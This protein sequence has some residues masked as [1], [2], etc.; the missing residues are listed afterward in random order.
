MLSDDGRV[1][2]SDLS[3]REK[4][5][6][7]AQQSVNFSVVLVGAILTVSLLHGMVPFDDGSTFLSDHI[8]IIIKGGAFYLLYVEVFSP[9]SKV[10]QFERAFDRIK[11]DPRCT[12]LLGNASEISAFG[13]STW[14][15]WARNR[16]IS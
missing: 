2:W 14:S 3:I 12:D 7:S 15:R 9:N 5:A 10:T 8:S 1:R 13:E 11:D 6:R 16:P 4:I